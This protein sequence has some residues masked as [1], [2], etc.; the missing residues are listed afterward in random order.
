MPPASVP[1]VRFAPLAASLSAAA[2]L[3]AC[4]AGAEP[5][6]TEGLTGVQTFT[7]LGNTHVEGRV[8]YPQD[9]PVG[10]DHNLDWLRCEVYDEPVPAEF[11]VHSL[12]HGGVWLAHDPDLPADEVA[13][14]VA[15]R[16]TDA[17]TTEYVLVSPY[18]GLSAPVVASVWGAQLPVQSATDPE[19]AD[20]VTR[21]AGGGQGGEE[22]APCTSSPRA[23]TP[24]QAEQVLA[25]QS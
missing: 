16:A 21:F 14:L 22:G 6:D 18:E 24:E 10:G 25:A 7:D 2:V 5:P 23:L 20:F 15:L 3:T 1:R 8:D 13:A 11:A 19:L 12:E 17:T 9:P 4:S